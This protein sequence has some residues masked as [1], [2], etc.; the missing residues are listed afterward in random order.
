ML[1]YFIIS[2][3]SKSQLSL[4]PDN[5]FDSKAPGLFDIKYVF[6]DQEVPFSYNKEGT[7]VQLNVTGGKSYQLKRNDNGPHEDIVVT[8]KLDKLNDD[9]ASIK[10][11]VKNTGTQSKTIS[12]GTYTRFQIR[13]EG[14]VNVKKL[15]GNPRS[16][17]IYYPNAN[18]DSWKKLIFRLSDPQ[19]LEYLS[20]TPIYIPPHNFFFGSIE[21]SDD[22]FFQK[23]GNP[24]NFDSY[25]G[26]T[27]MV[28]LSYSW[29]NVTIEQGGLVVL[30][31]HFLY[32]W[33]SEVQLLPDKLVYSF[34]SEEDIY[35]GSQIVLPKQGQTYSPQYRTD[36]GNSIGD[37][38]SNS[39]TTYNDDIQRRGFK[40]I[41]ANPGRHNYQRRFF[42]INSSSIG[43]GET[44]HSEKSKLI[45]LSN[46]NK[47]IK[48]DSTKDS[49]T[50]EV[51]VHSN[52]TTYVYYMIF[53]N[54]FNIINFT[55]R[56]DLSTNST[57][58]S[59][60]K[61][62]PLTSLERGEYYIVVKAFNE[63]GL[64]ADKPY[65]FSTFKI[66]DNTKIE[67][68]NFDKPVY[69]NGDDIIITGKF[70]DKDPD[71]I[72][73]FLVRFG[74]S[75]KE[76]KSN[77]VN[78][79]ETHNFTITVRGGP[80]ITGD[81]V[82]CTLIARDI[83][84]RDVATDTKTVHISN[85][86]ILIATPRNTGLVFDF[87]T[88]LVF[89]LTI[90]DD[91]SRG[92]IKW[93][94]D[95]DNDTIYSKQY[96]V[97]NR[98]FTDPLTVKLSDYNIVYKSQKYKLI[99]YAVDYNNI[100]SNKVPFSF[101]IL[102]KPV[103]KN[104][105][106]NQRGVPNEQ[107]ILKVL[108]DDY[109]TDKTLHLYAGYG[110][111]TDHL[112]ATPSNGQVNQTFKTIFKFP[113]QFK[114][115]VNFFLSS[116]SD[117]QTVASSSNTDSD[118]WVLEI[119]STDIPEVSA[120]WPELDIYETGESIN[121]NL[122]VTDD[123]SGS[124]K[125]TITGNGYNRNI[126][127]NP[128]RYEFSS[129]GSNSKTF[130]VTIPIPTDC[131][132]HT[133]SSG[134]YLYVQ[135]T[136]DYNASSSR[137]SYQFHI[138][139]KI[140]LNKATV[141]PN[142]IRPDVNKQVNITAYFKNVDEKRNIFLWTKFGDNAPSL[143]TSVSKVGE[144]EMISSVTNVPVD[145]GL[146]YP[147]SVWLADDYDQSRATRN[148]K[149]TVIT[150]DINITKAPSMT[151][152]CIPRIAY[153]KDDRIKISLE[154]IDDTNGMIEF[155]IDN[156]VIDQQLYYNTTNGVAKLSTEIDIPAKYKVFGN[157][158]IS[159]YPVDEFGLRPTTND[160][161]T[162]CPFIYKNKPLL[163]KLKL[164]KTVADDDDPITVSGNL[165]DYD[166]GK[167]LFIYQKLGSYDPI[168]LGEIVSQGG[169]SQNFTY[170][171]QK[172]K[173]VPSGQTSIEIY[174]SD[175][176]VTIDAS[177]LDRQAVSDP[178]PLSIYMANDPELVV[179]FPEETVYG[180]SDKIEIKV[181]I[182]ADI[183]GTVY[184]YD[185]FD[186]ADFDN[187]YNAVDHISY[188]HSCIVTLTYQTSTD[189]YENQ[190]LYIKA[191]GNN[192]TKSELYSKSFTIR[193]A[194]QLNKIQLTKD[195]FSPGD[196]ITATYYFQIKQGGYFYICETIY[197]CA[198]IGNNILVSDAINLYSYGVY[199]SNSFDIKLN[200]SQKTGPTTLTFW[201]QNTPNVV[202]PPE[203]NSKS[204]TITKNIIITKVPNVDFNYPQEQYYGYDDTFQCNAVIKDDT[205]G[206]ILLK[207]DDN[208]IKNETYTSNEL[209]TTKSFTF[210]IPKTVKYRNK[211]THVQPYG[212]T[213]SNEFTVTMS[214][215]D[216]YGMTKQKSQTFKF[217]N[218]PKVTAISVTKDL[219]LQ[220][221]YSIS[222]RINYTDVDNGKY[223]YF[224]L[225]FDDVKY[226]TSGSVTSSGK[227]ASDEF[228]FDIP[229]NK[230]VGLHT[231][232]VKA[233]DISSTYYTSNRN[234]FSN[235]ES[236]PIRV[237]FRPSIKLDRI[238]NNFISK[239]QNLRLTGSLSFDTTTYCNIVV[240]FGS[241]QA[242]STML[243]KSSLINGKYDIT[244]TVP[245]GL[246]FGITT[247]KVSAIDGNSI[248]SLNSGSRSFTY[249]NKPK[250]HDFS[251]SADYLTTG[252]KASF[253]L[254]LDDIDDG[255][256]IFVW[257]Q[258]GDGYP[259]CG[260]MDVSNGKDNQ[261][262]KFSE[263][264]YTAYSGPTNVLFYVTDTSDPYYEN[265][266]G[267]S[268]SNVLSQKIV[269]SY[270]PFFQ[271]TYPSDLYYHT[272]ELIPISYTC[273]DEGDVTI[274]VT[275]NGLSIDSMKEIISPNNRKISGTKN[276]NLTADIFKYGNNTFN[277]YVVNKYGFKSHD[278]SIN[279]RIINPPVLDSI[280]ISKNYALQGDIIEFDGTFTDLD[281]TK[282][283]YFYVQ[284][285][286]KAVEQSS[287][288]VLS[289]GEKG[290]KF[291]FGLKI[292]NTEPIGKK[293]I[294][295]WI[296]SNNDPK[297]VY[298][299]VHLNSKVHEFDFEVTYTP[300]ISLQPLVKSAYN[301]GEN[302]SLRGS[303]TANSN[304]FMKF[305][306]DNIELNVTKEIQVTENPQEFEV[307]LQIPENF[308]YGKHNLNAYAVDANGLSTGLTHIE[309]NI[310]N[311]PRI[312][313]ISLESDSVTAGGKAKVVGT[314]RDPDH[315][316]RITFLA[317]IDLETKTKVYEILSDS[318]VQAFAFEINITSNIELGDHDLEVI[319]RDPDNLEST[320][321]QLTFTVVK[322]N[323]GNGGDGDSSNANSKSA[324]KKKK[325][326]NAG[327]IAG[328]VIVGLVLVVLLVL[329]VVL[330]I[331]KSGGNNAHDSD[332]ETENED[333]E[334]SETQIAT[335][336]P[337]E[338]ATRDNPLFSASEVA[339]DNNPFS[340]EFEE[341]DHVD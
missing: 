330:L 88:T 6:N 46:I 163:Q 151:S 172:L 186:D 30:G 268:F 13:N 229:S 280:H 37:Q 79:S 214:V 275:I 264:I 138:K 171:I 98:L 177:K 135:C 335:S 67:S 91:D 73:T 266:D 156:E 87:N 143:L 5:E 141:V 188:N 310:Q 234:S 48:Y 7:Q 340:D 300:I 291:S 148:G 261:L 10:F 154:V 333:L 155:K 308:R 185:N 136:D 331:K 173:G 159:Y 236:I 276:I 77:Q 127:A 130:P 85:P 210:N 311:P 3:I 19:K 51:Q 189:S 169:S 132:Y 208:V 339:N 137:L 174:A 341:Q 200:L 36:N 326:T 120:Q 269:F 90:S 309:F 4:R 286:E 150:V 191:I 238:S 12:L 294:K 18:T 270:S 21:S 216:E 230:K 16:F 170:T 313:S 279:I 28:S 43:T 152:P 27:S 97:D 244:V 318:S 50:F 239:G 49:I 54:E 329:L 184:L 86:P 47:N 166:S 274:Y 115:N 121:F 20:L 304:I 41:R 81:D 281:Q 32:Q 295:V 153:G 65:K 14:N 195:A 69:A 223:L 337:M 324:N 222:V 23:F 290:Q 122:T 194:P 296:S 202:Y 139:N 219:I 273:E 285:G 323:S 113:P 160:S 193:E 277:M 44:N 241:V 89:D 289:T 179:L 61:I 147:V 84:N 101:N 298:N 2:A 95:N 233:A 157:H 245:D 114:G 250:I 128:N 336:I 158:S 190:T 201:V 57:S 251:M 31:I 218:K 83:N 68:W 246:K 220:D 35:V 59:F 198:K 103:I 312:L 263:T 282:D 283:L 72:L 225:Y 161:I 267:L 231:I 247:M 203:K 259:L 178:F 125:Y 58:A 248:K 317:G 265:P 42:N 254:L 232:S 307:K 258:I 316:N 325:A 76:Y 38:N 237:T 8:T 253:K 334:E 187:T 133:V 111:Q 221:K 144:N 118:P 45:V 320:P 9:V 140:V 327:L 209:L 102:S 112:Y 52:S 33:E 299:A 29:E 256:N 243:D 249:K 196:T 204:A 109:D 70:A 297:I 332:S 321:A 227:S 94:F 212:Y 107:K 315:G 63:F 257:M 314:I 129:F 182:T 167:K 82:L 25:D 26:S 62:I 181:N 92:D 255:K 260:Y 134:Y 262:L 206:Y 106:L 22:K 24:D 80:E 64:I 175:S 215:V 39:F 180:T 306:I 228:T 197:L 11:V 272:N 119:I 338:E 15:N 240:S 78:S 131:K 301:D 319:A 60:N 71:E 56:C 287:W 303:V 117:L 199:L 108:F 288:N 284:L 100:T 142:L 145:S 105:E 162:K 183:Q 211:R 305:K 302:I 242:P 207:V 124:I 1:S 66:G 40:S 278:Q 104:I 176:N 99:I 271:V 116:R 93:Y 74:N 123:N 126:E 224:W 96:S 17:Y 75:G 34:S 293:K 226:S 53:K 322:G 235:I 217:V 292:N 55:S 328:I 149:T 168:V 213:Y 192:D 252:G 164:N 110:S 205:R 146:N 165:V